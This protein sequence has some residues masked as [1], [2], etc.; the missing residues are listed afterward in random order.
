MPATPVVRRCFEGPVN[1]LHCVNRRCVD[2][3]GCR[4]RRLLERAGAQN[5]VTL[6][7]PGLAGG[8]GAVVLAV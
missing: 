6:A 5:A 3:P 4:L 2:Q 1:L 8:A 7:D